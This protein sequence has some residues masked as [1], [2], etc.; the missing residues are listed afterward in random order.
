M[1]VEQRTDVHFNDSPDC[2]SALAFAYIERIFLAPDPMLAAVSAIS[3]LEASQPLLE[4]AGFQKLVYEDF[5][6]TLVS[7][8]NSI[9]TPD[10]NGKVLTQTT[11]LEA[12]NT[13]EGT[14]CVRLSDRS[15]IER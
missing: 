3:I 6:D 4:A 9:V 1:Y 15:S 10:S 13:P 7:L 8:I 11:L 14:S 12:F 2:S 5:Y